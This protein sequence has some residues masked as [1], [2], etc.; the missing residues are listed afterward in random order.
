MKVEPGQRKTTNIVL[1]EVI[2]KD[3]ADNSFMWVQGGT[4]QTLG[5]KVHYRLG[6]EFLHM[7]ETA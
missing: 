4:D 6:K 7:Q 5:R 1:V 2:S 3:V